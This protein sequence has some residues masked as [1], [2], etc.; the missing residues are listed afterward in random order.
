M[1]LSLYEKLYS[2]VADAINSGRL[3]PGDLVSSEKEL[4][5]QFSVSRITSKKHLSGYIRIG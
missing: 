4:A 3:T 5:E 2:Q 1:K